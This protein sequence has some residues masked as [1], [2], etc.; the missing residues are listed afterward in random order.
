[1]AVAVGW[2]LCGGRGL[3]MEE[4][5][6]LGPACGGRRITLLIAFQMEGKAKRARGQEDG[7]AVG[8]VCVVEV[9]LRVVAD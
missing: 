2:F 3:A 8:A 9:P 1:L 7:G 4:V 6:G 5:A